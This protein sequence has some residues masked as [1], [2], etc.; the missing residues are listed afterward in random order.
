MSFDALAR[1]VASEVAVPRA[2]EVL[3]AGLAGVMA[4]GKAQPGDKTMVDAYA[5]ARP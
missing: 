4:Y 3:A 5:P 1:Y 2:F